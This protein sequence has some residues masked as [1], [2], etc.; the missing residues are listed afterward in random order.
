M[1]SKWAL[2][3]IIFIFFFNFTFA[4]QSTLE[5]F[6]FAGI[7]VS[8]ASKKVCSPFSIDITNL[9][10]VGFGI[11]S[12]EAKFIGVK[13]DNSFVSV[14]INGAEELII[15]PEYFSEAGYARV[16]LPKLSVENTQLELCLNTGGATESANLYKSSFVGLYDTPVLT[17]ENVSPETILLGEKAKMKIVVKNIGSKDT[18]FF[19]Q[20][21]S[22]DL[23][24]FLEITSFDIIDGSSSAEGT[25][26]AG[27]TKEFNF[28]IIPSKM[29]AY[30]LP[31]SI[32][33]FRNIFGEEQ[34]LT[35]GHPQLNVLNP[36]QITTD[37]T[38]VD[39]GKKLK[40]IIFIRNNWDKSF[41]GTFQINPQDLIA[42][43]TQQINLPPM[44]EKEIILMTDNLLPGEYTF[45]ST[46]FDNNKSYSSNSI[47][48]SVKKDDLSF[49]IILA[50]LAIIAAVVIFYAINYVKKK[51]KK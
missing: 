43:S 25:L 45:I 51:N 16:F 40:L 49:G 14:K 35:S 6:G 30:N 15:W 38:S 2:F 9:N 46:V 27:E 48:Y 24:S 42:S 31:Y 20:F 37:L 39:L 18:N 44:G 34:T 29:S 47:A 22:K 19:V 36:E 7:E 50:V 33:K 41:E 1:K 28:A 13:A 26:L 3:I 23:R 17:I 10:E 4:Y 11:L 12:L 21:V 5:E 32:I 8:G